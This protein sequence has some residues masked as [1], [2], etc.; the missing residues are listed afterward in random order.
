MAN[1]KSAK[2]RVLI[3]QRNTERN[4]AFK[5]SIKTAVK[6]VLACAVSEDKSELNALLSK[7][8]QLCD[9][10]AGKGILHKNTAARKKSRLTKA[11]N[12]IIN[13]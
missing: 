7:V 6:K 2:K 1:I 4:V 12:K 10:A 9:K 5:T 3:A 11:V 8:Y 13:K